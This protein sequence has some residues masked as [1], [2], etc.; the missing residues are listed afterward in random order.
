MK[1]KLTNQTEF[2]FQARSVNEGFARSAV[3]SF[4]SQLDPDIAELTDIRTVVS[5]GVTNAVVHGYRGMDPMKCEVTVIVK[6][7]DDRSIQ[8]KIRDRGCGIEDIEQAR[9]PLFT[10][11]GSGERG[12]MGFAIM[13]SFTDRMKVNSAPGRGTL[14]TLWKKF[15]D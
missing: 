6:L 15:K 9:R 3:S 13:E 7:Y 4:V 10:T 2:T 12:G 8:L 14:L 1:R 11:D 5:E